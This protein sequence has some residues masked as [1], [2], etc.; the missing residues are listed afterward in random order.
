MATEG[1]EDVKLSLKAVPLD[2]GEYPKWRFGV[3][4]KVLSAAKDPV[5]ALRYLTEMDDATDTKMLMI[6]QRVSN[7]VCG[8]SPVELRKMYK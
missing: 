8:P 2:L 4:S 7:I 1:S 3:R 5:A 6:T